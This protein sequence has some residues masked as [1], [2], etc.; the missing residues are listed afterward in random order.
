M[1]TWDG[2]SQSH[3]AVSRRMNVEVMKWRK[4]IVTVPCGSLAMNGRKCQ[5]LQERKGDI[6]QETYHSGCKN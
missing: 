3:N 2:D 6:F 1:K 5:E 4:Q